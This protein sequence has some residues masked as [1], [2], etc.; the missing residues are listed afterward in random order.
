MRA[1][2]G[3]S[4]GGTGRPAVVR[5]EERNMTRCPKR[6]DAD[7]RGLY[8]RIRIILAVIRV[9]II[10]IVDNGPLGLH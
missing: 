2:A 7:W 10:W 1:I 8:W 6:N 3:W 5:R 9:V 4:G